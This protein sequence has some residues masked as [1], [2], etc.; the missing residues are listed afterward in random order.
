[1]GVSGITGGCFLLRGVGF[2]NL[3]SV[4]RMAVLLMAV[5]RL[6]SAARLVLNRGRG[7]RRLDFIFGCGGFALHS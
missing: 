2:V 3:M 7:A 6:R 1:M 5:L 4:L